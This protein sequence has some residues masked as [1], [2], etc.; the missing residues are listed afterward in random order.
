MFSSSQH[1]MNCLKE[2]NK[3][4][5]DLPENLKF[6]D[7]EEEYLDPLS[8]QITTSKTVL[9]L[10]LNHLKCTN[11][12]GPSLINILKNTSIKE[13]HLSYCHNLCFSKE[14]LGAFVNNKTIESLFM[15][16]VYCSNDKTICDL[17]KENS[18]IKHLSIS[19]WYPKINPRNFIQAL[20]NNRSLTSLDIKAIQF[21]ESMID[22][23]R[24]VIS[25]SKI[26]Q[27][28][29]DCSNIFTHFK[30]LSSILKKNSICKSQVLP[31]H[32]INVTGEVKAVHSPV[33]TNIETKEIHNP[34]TGV[35]QTLNT[36]QLNDIKATGEINAAQST[37]Y[38]PMIDLNDFIIVP[39][40]VPP[41]VETKEAKYP[42]TELIATFNSLQ[43]IDM[44]T[45]DI[46][47]GIKVTHSY[48][49]GET[50]AA[51]NPRTGIVP[52][53]QHKA[54]ITK[55]NIGEANAEQSTN[56]ITMIDLNDFV[57]V[58]LTSHETTNK[59]T[60][61]EMESMKHPSTGSQSSRGKSTNKS[62]LIKNI[63]I[64]SV[65]NDY[66]LHNSENDKE[67]KYELEFMSPKTNTDNPKVKP[68]IVTKSEAIQS[69][70][71]I[72]TLI[73]HRCFMIP[74]ILLYN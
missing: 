47:G 58:P 11:K 38:I 48:D 27:L 60:L 73:P 52:T 25:K 32:D 7:L 42:S 35:V 46:T 66:S 19:E 54:K 62:Q 45:Q 18:T 9:V 53:L 1:I 68:V 13:F 43:L 74:R 3:L 33:L 57:A 39:S 30:D 16:S 56:I 4:P 50:K 59:N 72:P 63:S 67:K 36:L 49:T 61:N 26:T 51:K 20:K 14:L 40:P 29:T 10:S 41:T 65:N 28:S 12:S 2:G 17:I 71:I 24:E 31:T 5:D 44:N 8:T 21:Q 70:L 34:R 69:P 23:L 15:N 55:D 37:N 22:E 6:E 64:A